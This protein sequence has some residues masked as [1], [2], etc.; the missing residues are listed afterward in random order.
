M[1]STPTRHLS[2]RSPLVMVLA[3]FGA[4]TAA[5]YPKAGAVPG[6]ADLTHAKTVWPDATEPKLADGRATFVAH[7]NNCHNYP[8]VNAIEASKWPDILDAM[9]KKADLDAAHKDEVLHFILASR[10]QP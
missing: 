4:S 2:I 9:A 8:D 5:C 6:P 3:I 10:A 7:C 1:S